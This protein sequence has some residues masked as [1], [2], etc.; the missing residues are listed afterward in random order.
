MGLPEGKPSSPLHPDPFI[1]LMRCLPA[2]L[3]RWGAVPCQ[4]L[5]HIGLGWL[6]ELPA[7]LIMVWPISSYEASVKHLVAAGAGGGRSNAGR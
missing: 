3:I 1:Y 6:T 7:Q 4:R 5:H 2:E